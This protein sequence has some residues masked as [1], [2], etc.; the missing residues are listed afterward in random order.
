MSLTEEELLHLKSTVKY[1]DEE[2]DALNAF[3]N[4]DSKLSSPLVLINGFKPIGKTLLIKEFLEVLDIN[5]S[6]IQCD[7]CITQHMLLQR[8][9]NKIRQD[10][11]K[12]KKQAP[13]EILQ[14]DQ[15]ATFI[16][17]LESFILEYKYNEPHVLV[18]D[19]FDECFEN[20]DDLL[21]SFC[22]IREFTEIQNLTV[23]AVF[24]GSIP[25]E[26]ITYSVPTVFLPVYKEHEV[27]E[28]LQSL[29]LCEFEFEVVNS[30]EGQRL[31]FYNQYVKAVVDSFFMYTG[32]DLTKLK[33]LV[34]KLWD[35]FIEPLMFGVYNITEFL[36]IYKDNITLFT[37]ENI[38]ANC[39]VIE[40]KTLREEEEVSYGNILDLPLHS[41][42]FLL[43]SYL[44]SFGN[45]RNDLH[46]YSKVKAFK[47]KKRASTK[48]IKQGHLSKDDIDSRLLT[49][50]F[51]DLERILA[52]LSVIY[53]NFAPSFN[54]SDKDDL[55]Y[56]GDEVI[57]I[58][59]K[60]ELEK[61]NFTLT[62]NIDLNNQI[63]TLYSL[64]FLSKTSS[65]DILAARIR[66]KC[67]IDWGM[68]KSIADSVN[69]PI[70][71]YLIDE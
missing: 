38:I 39:N 22:K 40:F 13:K 44:A 2:I 11:G 6:I 37:D 19:R 61:S 57:E 14:T 46:K 66:W 33:D 24:G 23:V 55:L 34:V 5:H 41:K 62:K 53:R 12:F 9:Y 3:I 31:E 18:L 67:N 63:A 7:E 28:I 48:A 50:N 25:R 71:D 68:A 29:K 32:S 43:A 17:S 56:L 51:V 36:K 64:G 45:Q 58:E 10:S 65:S 52:I 70:L 69:F 8:C 21:A 54:Q 49:A 60:K 30:T 47:Y 16:S 35:K 15:I 26:I 59:Q 4:R 1:R 27:V 42:F 20:C